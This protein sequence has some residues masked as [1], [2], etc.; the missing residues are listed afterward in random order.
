ML[1]VDQQRQI[2]VLFRNRIV[3]EYF[4]DLVVEEQL[5]VELKAVKSLLPERQAQ[6]INYLC[7]SNIDTGLLINFAKKG[8]GIKRCSSSNALG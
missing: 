7:A 8:L 5:V 6:L 4:A 3:G 1:R 2:Q